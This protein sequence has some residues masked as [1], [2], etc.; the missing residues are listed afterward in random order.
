[1][2]VRAQVTSFPCLYPS[3]ELPEHC[4]PC[5]KVETEAV[6]IRCP[7]NS[8]P[9]GCQRAF[10][11]GEICS[12]CCHFNCCHLV[13]PCGRTIGKG[14]ACFHYDEVGEDTP[15]LSSEVN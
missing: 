10:W 1:M 9:A 8:R 5:S 15:L 4:A 3:H 7:A 13:S 12:S 2:K 11:D 6:T 14:G